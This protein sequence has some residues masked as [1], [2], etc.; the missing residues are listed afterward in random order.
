MLAG[1]DNQGGD[2]PICGGRP[3]IRSGSEIPPGATG[4]DDVSWARRQIEQEL[5][6]SSR[7]RGSVR[8][9]VVP[10]IRRREVAVRRGF[11]SGDGDD[12]RQNRRENGGPQSTRRG[13]RRG[14]AH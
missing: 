12:D 11:E 2:G 7:A 6:P 8:S 3:I 9:R 4:P 1:Q 14:S 5:N 10:S 13:T